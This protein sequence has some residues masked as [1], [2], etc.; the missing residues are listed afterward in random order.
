MHSLQLSLELGTLPLD[1]AKFTCQGLNLVLV[2][3]FLD[4][5]VGGINRGK[6]RDLL[7]DFVGLPLQLALEPL[8][9][10]LDAS[11]VISLALDLLLKRP[12]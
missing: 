10:Q 9:L 4:F 11:G 7:V 8:S 5:V 12:S 1:L 3:C 6:F 2:S